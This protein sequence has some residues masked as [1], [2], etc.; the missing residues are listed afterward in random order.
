MMFFRM[1]ASGT[2][3]PPPT[4]VGPDEIVLVFEEK[5]K[6]ENND[7]NEVWWGHF[8]Q[9]KTGEKGPYDQHGKFCQAVAS[10]TESDLE[11]DT[12]GYLRALKEGRFIYVYVTTH[13][14]PTVYLT[15]EDFPD[16]MCDF[17]GVLVLSRE[18]TKRILG[19]IFD[20][21]ALTRSAM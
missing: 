2:T 5:S 17:L 18:V 4:Q 14:G 6:G 10:I 20:V 12:G 7:S 21:Y 16:I 3:S 11:G 13:G 9:G 8:I 1:L 15:A 19:S